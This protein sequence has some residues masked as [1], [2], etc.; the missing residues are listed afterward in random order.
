MLISKSI[1]LI[2]RRKWSNENAE[3]IKSLVASLE[4]SV[5]FD[6]GDVG[7][8]LDHDVIYSGHS[9]INVPELPY[10]KTYL[11]MKSVNGN[12]YGVIFELI[13]G[14][15][16]CYV[17][18]PS[19]FNSK[20]YL[21]PNGFRMIE[22]DNQLKVIDKEFYDKENHIKMA[23]QAYWSVHFAVEALNLINCSNIIIKDN[24]PSKFINQ[25][26][27]KKGK[28]PLFCYKT[29]HIDTGER[30]ET[31]GSGTGTHASPRVHLR[32]GHIRKLANGKTVW[33][34]PCLVGNKDNGIVHKDYSLE[35]PTTTHL[36]IPMEG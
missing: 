1:D 23:S 4:K 11:E 28:A 21:F 22:E 29:L 16:L 12:H 10:D 30:T 15:V 36:E 25:K 5:K 9:T 14:Y 17:L 7:N 2:K 6:I 13:D 31:K 35:E 34:Q 19:Y 20:E 18:I 3:H 26:R 32:R 8:L 33:V 24:Q 27:K